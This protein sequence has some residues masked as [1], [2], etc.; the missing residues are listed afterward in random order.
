M[1]KVIK[2]PGN[3]HLLKIMFKTAD[4]ADEVVKGGIEIIFQ[5]FAG[6]NVDKEIFIP[7]IIPCYQCYAYGHQKKL[8]Q[9]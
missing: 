4:M 7:I 6:K 3:S 2:T 8:S 9:K 5:K 1:K